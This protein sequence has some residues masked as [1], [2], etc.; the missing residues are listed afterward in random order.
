MV[1]AKGLTGMGGDPVLL[2]LF[3]GVPMLVFTLSLFCGHWL[4][5]PV[6]SLWLDKLCIRQTRTELKMKGVSALPA[7][8]ANSDRMVILWSGTYFEHLWCNAEV[9]TFAAINK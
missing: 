5:V 9:A 6:H 2:L 3:V 8:V 1:I 7:V 4:R